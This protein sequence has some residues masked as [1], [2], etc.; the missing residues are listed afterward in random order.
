MTDIK[1]TDLG[2]VIAHSGLLPE[3]AYF[4]IQFLINNRDNLIHLL[5][6]TIPIEKW[7]EELA[8]D[9]Q[10]D[11]NENDLTFILS[12]LCFSS[13]EYEDTDTPHRRFIP[14]MLADQRRESERIIRLQEYLSVKPWDKN[15]GA[16]NAS[17]IAADFVI[18]A[19]LAE[20]EDRFEGLSGGTIYNMLRDQAAHLSGLGD[21]IDVLTFPSA[22]QARGIA[23][24][25]APDNNI[26][27]ALRLLL[28]RIRQLTMQM[29]LGVPE[30]VLWMRELLNETGRPILTRK[31]II[32]L[33]NRNILTLEDLLDNGKRDKF[34]E[35]MNSIDANNMERKE[36]R[37]A[38]ESA[39]TQRTIHKR[40]RLNKDLHN[41]HNLIGNY[42]DSIGNEFEDF[43]N[44]CF[45]CLGVNVIERDNDNRKD[46]FPDFVI[47]II[48][49]LPV[50]IECKS[51]E[52]TNDVPLGT[53][54]EIGAKAT[55]HG[56]NRN[57][58]VTICQP[59]VCTDVPRKIK[60]AEDLSVVNAED[61]AIAMAALKNE[62]IS[63]ERF[64][65]W[66]TTP[67]QP[68]I[69]DLFRQ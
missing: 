65:S 26:R 54:T 53:A 52:N 35:A 31:A 56:L 47:E 12:N 67:G 13:P 4:F 28:R 8:E 69:N 14:Y 45:G 2:R 6:N 57:P 38:A 41:C 68:L 3:T 33:R 27:R 9:I 61:L 50:I 17:E 10:I 37:T 11:Q 62:K 19:P 48:E 23:R 46:R 16:I 30:D 39:R 55:A 59:Y 24:E 15:V 1:I 22:V 34:I 42:F 25:L 21:I 43:L 49:G 32:A 7:N 51:K 44:D 64:H 66:L 20:L 60:Q 29:I 5:P 40:D 63:K 18:G 36:I 58:M